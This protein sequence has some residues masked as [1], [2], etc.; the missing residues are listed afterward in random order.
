MV[1]ATA[2]FGIDNTEG[3][4]NMPRCNRTQHGLLHRGKR[5]RVQQG[6]TQLVRAGRPGHRQLKVPALHGMQP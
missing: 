5:R 1:P 3:Q 4:C 2:S 6:K